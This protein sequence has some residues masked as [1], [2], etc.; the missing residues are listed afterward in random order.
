[1]VLVHLVNNNKIKHFQKKRLLQ[2]LIFIVKLWSIMMILKF[3][4]HWQ[5]EI[6]MLM[7]KEIEMLQN[8]LKYLIEVLD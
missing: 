3:N 7:I 8:L 4:F 6:K 1:M 2:K 5:M